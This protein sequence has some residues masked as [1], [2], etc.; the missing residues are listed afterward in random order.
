M[1]I[2]QCGKQVCLASCEC[3][4]DYACGFVGPPCIHSMYMRRTRMAKPPRHPLLGRGPPCLRPT[5]LLPPRLTSARCG[6]SSLSCCCQW[7][8]AGCL[9]SARTT[10]GRAQCVEIDVNLAR[11]TLTRI[12]VVQCQIR[13]APEPARYFGFGHISDDGPNSESGGFTDCV[14]TRLHSN[15]PGP[16]PSPT[17]LSFRVRNASRRAPETNVMGA[18]GG[19]G[20]GLTNAQKQRME[21][22]SN[23]SGT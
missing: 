7:L 13:P 16:S 3:Q 6:P 10:L 15:A 2:W 22:A 18:Q 4:T 1:Q 19:G 5:F 21:Q 14:R 8:V 12:G 23:G 17:R 20:G 11:I 9:P